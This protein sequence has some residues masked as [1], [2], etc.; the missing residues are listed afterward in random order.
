M[1]TYAIDVSPIDQAVLDWVLADRRKSNPDNAPVDAADLL[2]RAVEGMILTPWRQDQSRVVIASMQSQINDA[3]PE[4]QGIALAALS[5]LANATPEQQA[6]A[7]SEL[8]AKL[9][10]G[11]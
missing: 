7:L 4:V 3:T 2:Q 8:A 11:A 10:G 6:A 1:T 5:A 9:S